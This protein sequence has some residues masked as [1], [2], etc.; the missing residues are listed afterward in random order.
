M[1]LEPPRRGLVHW[2]LLG[3]LVSFFCC[4]GGRN[5]LNIALHAQVPPSKEIVG[6]AVTM[7]GVRQA[8]L[9]RNRTRSTGNIGGSSIAEGSRWSVGNVTIFYPFE[10]RGLHDRRWDLVIIEGWF[11]MINSFIH[12]VGQVFNMFKG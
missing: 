9:S 5:S 4:A 7:A 8:F 3:Y 6:S 1:G 11:A 10:Y 12:E 2:A